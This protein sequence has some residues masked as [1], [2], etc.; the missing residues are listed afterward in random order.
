[1]ATVTLS[2]YGKFVAGT[3][4]VGH[5]DV[6]VRL[7]SAAD[8]LVLP[9]EAPVGFK[10]KA[11][12]NGAGTMTF[13]AGTGATLVAGSNAGTA[14]AGTVVDVVNSGTATAAAWIACIY[15]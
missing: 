7:G 11:V 10:F 3:T 15:E 12:Q 2:T 6:L 4:P 1:M 9:A 8:D 14:V 13:S 5:G